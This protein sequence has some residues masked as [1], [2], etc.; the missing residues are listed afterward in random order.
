MQDSDI[1][2]QK[3]TLLSNYTAR[4]VPAWNMVSYSSSWSS[5][6]ELW[7][8]C[9]VCTRLNSVDALCSIFMG[10]YKV[11]TLLCCPLTPLYEAV[12]DLQM[13]IDLVYKIK[14]YS[15]VELNCVF[16]LC[17]VVH[18]SLPQNLD[19]KFKLKSYRRNSKEML[20][21]GSE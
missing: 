6:K 10:I 11:L 2:E 3:I 15:S 5:Q 20:Y 8:F 13:F 1:R 7:S 16:R 12:Q 19:K 4:G 9:A 21:C 18:P 14:F 17:C